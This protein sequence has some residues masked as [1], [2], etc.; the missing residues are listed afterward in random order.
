MSEIENPQR[1]KNTT[2]AH[3]DFAARNTRQ[4][5]MVFLTAAGSAKYV[6][7]VV[8]SCCWRSNGTGIRVLFVCLLTS[9]ILGC[10]HLQRSY[11]FVKNFVVDRTEAEVFIS[12]QTRAQEGVF[13]DNSWLQRY[14]CRHTYTYCLHSL[15]M[16]NA[17]EFTNLYYSLKIPRFHFSDWFVCI[18][19][20]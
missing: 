14:I 2:T 17:V 3:Y 18:F 9:V 4:S 10:V 15:F 20:E 12:Y 19:V 1:Q 11:C 6:G 5:T 16:G 8:F 13:H 7:L